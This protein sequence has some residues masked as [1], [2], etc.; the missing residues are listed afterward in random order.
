MQG[1][2]VRN[3]HGLAEGKWP[4]L[5]QFRFAVG[6]AQSQRVRWNS[7]LLTAVAVFKWPTAPR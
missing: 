5:D 3:L 2:E 4:T 6:G 7:Y 1:T